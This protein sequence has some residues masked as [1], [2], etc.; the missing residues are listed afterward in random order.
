MLEIQ[1]SF[2]NETENNMDRKRFEYEQTVT[3]EL[4]LLD[5]RQSSLE[6]MLEGVDEGNDATQSPQLGATFV[7]IIRNEINEKYDMLTQSVGKIR[8]ENAKMAAE[9]TKLIHR[10]Q[11]L[12]TENDKLID[13]ICQLSQRDDAV[14]NDRK[15]DS[16]LAELKRDFSREVSHIKLNFEKEI[17]ELKNTIEDL[18]KSRIKPSNSGSKASQRIKLD[19]PKYRGLENGRFC[20]NFKNT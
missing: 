5:E 3:E 9:M 16:R 2:D 17:S 1:A 6:N 15:I 8:T 18:K 20:R 14:R 7:A 19:I 12:E 13:Q 11:L 4:R 10:V